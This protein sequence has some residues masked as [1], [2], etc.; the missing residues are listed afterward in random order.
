MY[1]RC[2][3]FFFLKRPLVAAAAAAAAGRDKKM[4]ESFLVAVLLSA[5]VERFLVSH[6]RDFFLLI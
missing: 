2:I 6:M 4:L 1:C 3:F 5:S